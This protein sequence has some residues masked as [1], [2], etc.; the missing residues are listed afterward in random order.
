MCC[1]RTYIMKHFENVT[2]FHTSQAAFPTLCMKSPAIL[3]LPSLKL[4]NFKYPVLN[5]HI[6]KTFPKCCHIALHKAVLHTV[7]ANLRHVLYFTPP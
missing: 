7:H 2:I 4:P 5:P 3:F 1:L 6:I